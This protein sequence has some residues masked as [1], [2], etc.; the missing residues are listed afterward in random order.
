METIYLDTHVVVW[1]FTKEINKISKKALDLIEECEL[2]VS[3]MIVLELEFLYEIGRLNYT[4][5]QVL[6]SLSQSIDL[7]ICN[8]SFVTVAKESTK[9]K[10]TR[11]PFDRLIV[12]NAICNNNSILL[13]RDR[14]IKDNYDKAVW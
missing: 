1:L 5:E 12:A 6:S 7:K 11:D 3:A 14:K 8:L 2:L 10:W 13:S 4:H 9:H